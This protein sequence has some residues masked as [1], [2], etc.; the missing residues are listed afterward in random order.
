MKKLT[1]LVFCIITGALAAS[2]TGCGAAHSAAK[3]AELGLAKDAKQAE[4]F[5]TQVPM[6][7]P[8][9]ALHAP[10]PIKKVLHNELS[11]LA[12]PKPGL[13]LCSVSVII[14][15]GSA[16]DPG[17]LPGLAGFTAEMLKMGTQRRSA[18]ALAREVESLGTSIEISADDDAIV[19]TTTALKENIG[20]VME[21]LADQLLHPKF[22][23]EEVSRVRHMRLAALSQ[24][25]ND[26]HRSVGQVF[27]KVVYG[28]HPYAH[29]QLGSA[30]A[31][32]KIGAPHLEGYYAQ[33]FRPANAAVIV[34]GDVTVDEAQHLVD[35]HLGAWHAAVDAPSGVQARPVTPVEQPSEVTL[36]SRPGAPQSQLMIGELS[37]ARDTPDYFALTLCNAILGGMFNSR[38]NMNLREDKGY[39]YGA[40]SMFDL[41]R[42]RGTFVVATGVTTNVTAPAIKEIFME[43][44]KIRSAD[45][46][47]EE[48]HNAK[49]RYTLSLP[50]YF[51]TVDAVAYMVASLYLYDLPLDYYQR[52]PEQLERV[53]VADVRRV[54]QQYLHPDKLSVVVVG[55]PRQV[56][57]GLLELQRGPV[58]LRNA[59]G[60]SVRAGKMP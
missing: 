5:R 54:A 39:T 42:E 22:A 20:K 26:P 9:P 57:K 45:V 12:V 30:A 32:K 15:S 11:V 29:T 55:D 34:V 50:G 33:H 19:L 24:E 38:I 59:Q 18:Q 8:Q 46:E 10:V 27:G 44:D 3:D 16:Q 1:N 4:S 53:S 47:A 51:Q 6:T 48:L 37:V 60:D 21:V 41:H 43:I 31:L 17:H 23:R 35:L 13:P 56:E 49:N 14:K 28:D 7:G 40:H 25:H 2:S 58:H 52:L 36:V